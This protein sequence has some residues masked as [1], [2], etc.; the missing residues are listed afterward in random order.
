MLRCS[1]PRTPDNAGLGAF[2]PRIGQG[3][4]RGTIGTTAHSPI[5]HNA[6]EEAMGRYLLLWLLGIPIP[7]LVLIW[8][9]GGLH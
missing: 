3:I 6:T 2:V 9:L 8:L 5:A 1:P 7:L 4:G